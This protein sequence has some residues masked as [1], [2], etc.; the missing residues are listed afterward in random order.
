MRELTAVETA[1]LSRMEARLKELADCG[2][3]DVMKEVWPERA[4]LVREAFVDEFARSPSVKAEL[5]GSTEAKRTSADVVDRIVLKW[6]KDIVT[7]MIEYYSLNYDR[8]QMLDLLNQMWRKEPTAGGFDYP[9][10]GPS[11]DIQDNLF[12]NWNA[13]HRTLPPIQETFE[14]YC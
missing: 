13:R 1:N 9:Y 3:L 8:N 7:R 6:R 10:R 2:L 5:R 14:G 11:R 4:D 12:A